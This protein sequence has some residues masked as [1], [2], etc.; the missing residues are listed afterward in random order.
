VNRQRRDAATFL[1]RLAAAVLA[2]AVIGCVQAPPRE[3]PAPAP[4]VAPTSV[5]GE[6]GPVLA[7]DAEFAVVVVQP[8]EDLSRLA[9]RWLGDRSRRAVIA[10]FNHIEEARVGQ[11][12]A[13]PLKNRNPF[14]VRPNGVP[15]LTILAYHRFGP[16]AN[17][18]TVTPAAFEA[19]MAYLATNGYTVVP[20]ARL[21]AYLEGREPI[22]HKAVVITI[23]D[24]YRSTHEFAYPVLRKYK[25]HATVFLYTDFVG[26]P[27]ALTWA[28]MREMTA[29]G[30][31][32]LQP[33]SKTHSNLT[34][35]QN[36]EQEGR[37][38]ERVRRE[39][40]TPVDVIRSQLGLTSIAY[41][42]PYGDVND[43]VVGELRSKG[44][45][46]GVTVTPGGNAFFA[47]PYML[48][49]TMIFGGDDLEAFRAKLVTAVPVPRK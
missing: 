44:V 11:T 6:E 5:Q 2:V 32:D 31:I 3:T 4:F 30:L 12:I 23:D 1:A 39:V 26:A 43:T 22:P 19:Q 34:V 15:A 40:D 48:R 36:G 7:R 17:T 28:Q 21:P 37:Y 25:F 41:A 27:D 20:I 47:P 16:R 8:G 29:S 18:L 38:R 14:G 24:G 46:L 35:R 9:E 49:R 33:H 10:E 42:F 45:K 13:I